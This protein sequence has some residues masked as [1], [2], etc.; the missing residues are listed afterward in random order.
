MCVRSRSIRRSELILKVIGNAQY[1]LS[2]SV[3]PKEAKKLEDKA[4]EK[5]GLE[6][7]PPAPSSA[8]R[9]EQKAADAYALSSKEFRNF[10]LKSKED[11]NHNT[12]LFTFELPEGKESGLTVASALV[13]KSAESEGEKALLDDKGKPVIRPYT[14]RALLL[15]H[16]AYTG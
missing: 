3:S 16:V 1:A 15:L 13:T 7:P 6:V 11:Y 14:V 2:S 4:R 5:L 12:A 9:Q 8:E 10:K